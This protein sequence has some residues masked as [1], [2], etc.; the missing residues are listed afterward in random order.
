MMSLPHFRW[1]SSIYEPVQGGTLLGG[2]MGHSEIRPILYPILS[3]L[4]I[5]SLRQCFSLSLVCFYNNSYMSKWFWYCSDFV[6]IRIALLCFGSFLKNETQLK[7][8]LGPRTGVI[9]IFVSILKFQILGSF[10]HPALLSIAWCRSSSAGEEGEMV[11]R[12][13][14][15]VGVLSWGKTLIANPSHPSL[16]LTA[17]SHALHPCQ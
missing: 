16:W 7:V 4:P 15:K 5:Q 10:G 12:G 11:P 6:L 17:H 1:Q 2:R 13:R 8:F 9:P 3:S 14:W